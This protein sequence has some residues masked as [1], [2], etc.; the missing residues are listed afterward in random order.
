VEQCGETIRGEPWNG[1]IRH[2]GSVPS[3]PSGVE[4]IGN[5]PNHRVAFQNPLFTQILSWFGKTPGR[6]NRE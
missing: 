4:E 3:L 2:G 5:T 6:K 1:L